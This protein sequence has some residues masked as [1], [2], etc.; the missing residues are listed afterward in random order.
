MKKLVAVF[1][2][3]SVS[4]SLIAQSAVPLSVSWNVVE[5][6]WERTSDRRLL[7]IMSLNYPSRRLPSLSEEEY[8]ACLHAY[9]RRYP[10]STNRKVVEYLRTNPDLNKSPAVLVVEIALKNNRITPEQAA[11]L[12]DTDST[13]ER[14]GEILLTIPDATPMNILDDGSKEYVLS[15]NHT[16]II[17]S[18]G[19][20]EDYILSDDEF[21]ETLNKLLAA[22]DWMPARKH[23][24]DGTFVD[25]VNIRYSD[26]GIDP[27][28]V[29]G[30]EFGY[31]GFLAMIVVKGGSLYYRTFD[32]I[33]QKMEEASFFTPSLYRRNGFDDG[34]YLVA[35]W[36]NETG[37][38]IET[39]SDESVQLDFDR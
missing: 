12:M 27:E 9:T 2:L 11:V 35:W 33:G 38:P 26:F 23:M 10:N 13:P 16:R 39:D 21:H 14:V 29:I 32:R 15:E 19:T 37:Q 30:R 28:R 20:V 24:G 25:T 8:M 17:S 36:L 18:D 1:I 4:M 5:S 7:F 6:R 34:Y 3:F 22:V 31:S